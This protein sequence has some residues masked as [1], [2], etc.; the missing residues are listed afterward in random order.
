MYGGC[1]G[2]FEHKPKEHVSNTRNVRIK[3]DTIIERPTTE[4]RDDTIRAESMT[5]P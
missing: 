2:L 4:R 5:I 3:K 1:E